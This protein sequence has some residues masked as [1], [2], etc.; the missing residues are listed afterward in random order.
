[1]TF[2]HSFGRR[3]LHA[4]AFCCAVAFAALAGAKQAHADTTISSA[5]TTPLS[6]SSAGSVTVD[7]SGSVAVTGA[8]AAVTVDSDAAVS[9]AGTISAVSAGGIGID[10]TFAT[11]QKIDNSGTI[12]TGTAATSTTANDG[13]LGGPALEVFEDVGGGIAN[14]GTITTYGP[15]AILLQA[16]S[17]DIAI[18]DGSSYGF[19][20]TASIYAYGSNSGTAATAISIEGSGGHTV[21]LGTGLENSGTSS[22]IYASAIDADATAILLGNSA[23][24][25]EL[26]NEGTIEGY[27]SGTTGGD[28]VGVDIAAGA[29]LGTIDNAGAIEAIAV[30]DGMDA[31]AIRDVSGTLTSIDNS[32]TILATATTGSA[33]AIDLSG[34]SANVDISN[35]GTITGDILFGTG[36][37]TLTATAGTITGDIDVAS[38]GSATIALSGGATLKASS[39]SVGTLNLDV[40]D[41]TF[42]STGTGFDATT[43]HFGADSVFAVTYDPQNSSTAALLTTSGATSFDAGA[44]VD[45]TFNSYLSSTETIALVDAGSLS[46]TGGID[47]GGVS[48][49][50][51]ATL[52]TNGGQL[53]IT[54]SRKTAAELGLSQNVASIYD[55]APGALGSDD[56]FGSAVGNLSTV[57]AVRKLYSDLQPDLTGARETQA[58]RVQDISSGI[59]STRLALLRTGEQT[60]VDT[61]LGRVASRRGTGFWGQE[62]ISAEQSKAGDKSQAYDGP[63]YAMAAGYDER[64]REGDVWG[65]SF[66]YAAMNYGG[67]DPSN[68]N[69]NQSILVQAYK[70]INRG[71]FFLDLVGGIGYDN[72]REYRQVTASSVT[73]SANAKWNGYQGG[74]SAE[75]GYSAVLGPISIRPLIGASYTYLYQ[76]AYTEEGGQSI[77]LAVEGNSFQSL[78]SNAELRIAGTFGSDT[79]WTPYVRG[80]LSHEFLDAKPVADGHFVE[81]GGSFSLEGDPLDKDVPYVGGGLSMAIGYAR[82]SLDYT[83]QFGDR[84]QSHQGSATVAVAF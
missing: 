47:V 39:A 52:D 58:I 4:A 8:V 62:A 16:S 44:T 32:G 51:D 19:D 21:D 53:S 40:G 23:I 76:N 78:R 80:G 74:L 14:S 71:P 63:L 49:G 67:S 36:T 27:T 77:D 34:S 37:S 70:G 81:G 64:D 55:A 73:R 68:D 50:Y 79:L 66:A 54:L 41:A 10:V 33:T 56:T 60:G 75:I 24:V 57:D 65:L 28:A 83:G 2:R 3:G 45:V 25:P 18:G 12:K 84:L 61:S 17:T 22:I 48:A 42:Q 30:T 11:T 46:G 69:T 26:M 59:I 20:N 9:N 82:V 72:Y 29:T 38:G 5:T 43:A 13:V 15:L 6:T 31:T 35:S 1:M 7:S